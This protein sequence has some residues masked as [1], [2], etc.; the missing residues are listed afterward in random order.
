MRG[1]AQSHLLEAD[2][3]QF[4]VVKFRNN[5]QHRRILV[6]EWITTAV[7]RQL[8]IQAA[9]AAVVELGLDFIG[10]HPGLSLQVGVHQVAPLPGWHYGSRYPG[11]P[12]RIAVYDYLPDSLLETIHNRADF[13]GTLVVDRW[14]GNSDARQA[15]F[16]RAESRELDL[17]GS[18]PRKK[19]FIAQMIDHGFAFNGAMWDFPDSPLQGLYFRHS[20]YTGVRGLDSFE[21]WLSQVASFPVEALDRAWR[22]VP[23]EW[24]ADGDEQ[25]GERM[26]AS[27]ERRKAMVP[28]LLEQ[29]QSSRVGPFPSWAN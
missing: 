15:I 25:A 3:G 14:L 27:L 22:S 13:L 5:P 18:H 24:L 23:P 2:D 16:F 11:H 29:A 6:N 19:V 7:L 21:P 9:P 10:A 8:K 1:G 20:V 17:A 4:Y 12:E 28:R 26:I